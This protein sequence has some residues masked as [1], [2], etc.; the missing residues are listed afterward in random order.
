MI[1]LD[2]Q[3]D[4]L[5]RLRQVHRLCP[6]IRLGQLL[7]TI[8]MLGEDATGRSSRDIEDEDL[9]AAIERFAADLA[10]CAEAHS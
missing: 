7:A 1:A 5:Q 3:A 9:S 2:P 8:G 6:D 10:R 4:A